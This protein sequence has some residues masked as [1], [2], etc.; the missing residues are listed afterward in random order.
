[1]LQH[2]RQLVSSAYYLMVTRGVTRQ[3]NPYSSLLPILMGL[4][5]IL[6]VER[7]LELGS[8]LGS[9]PLFL[10]RSVFPNL[11]Q[12]DSLE[13]DASWFSTVQAAVGGDSRLNLTYV[14][15][16][17]GERVADL[18]LAPYDLVLVDDSVLVADRARTIRNVAERHTR[19][20]TV[21]IHDFET[22]QY[23][24]AAR[25]FPHQ[26]RVSSLNPNTGIAW[27]GNRITRQDLKMLDLVLR[28]HANAIRSDDRAAWTAAFAVNGALIQ[29]RSGLGEP[30]Q[31][32]GQ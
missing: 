12:I 2:M 32:G 24:S 3:P 30:G 17:I 9:T 16:S 21:V 10:D 26:H 25:S 18:D 19:N 20:N 1:M 22:R 4:S 5:R 11:C 6:S 7:V 28:R 23:R 29:T 27:Q 15:G 14:N 31:G 13:N 8:G